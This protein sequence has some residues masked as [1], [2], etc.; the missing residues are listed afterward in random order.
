MPGLFSRFRR[1]LG[2]E[3]DGMIARIENHEALVATA[4][5]EL[6]ATVAHAERER[7][8][9]AALGARLVAGVEEARETALLWR[10]RALRESVEFRAVECL[11]RSK[12]AE[13]RV[14]ELGERL[15][16]IQDIE[17]RFASRALALQAKLAEFR[18]QEALLR[19][20]QSRTAEVASPGAPRTPVHD[21]GELLERWEAQVSVAE[22]ARDSELIAREPLD[23]EPLDAAEE[24]ALVL[25][26][27]DLKEK[28]R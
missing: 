5:R 17:R 20:R 25:E 11:R 6:E 27:R 3:L 1:R 18:E 7:A 23:D 19:A 14:R 24:A 12:H 2:A 21:L 26:L 9:A 22:S 13:R 4:V 8:R 16:E 10:E 15:V 28:S